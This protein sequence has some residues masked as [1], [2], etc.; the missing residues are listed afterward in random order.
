MN[1][2]PAYKTEMINTDLR[3]IQYLFESQGEK[4]IIK[5]IEYSLFRKISGRDVYN[6]GFGDYDEDNGTLIDDVNSNNGDMRKVFSTVLNSVPKF[7]STNKDSV[8]WVQGSDSTEE[9]KKNCKIDCKKNCDEICKKFNR[10]IKTYRYYVDKNFVEL[11]KEYIF[12][13]FTDI[14][15]PDFVQYIPENEYLGILVFK[16]K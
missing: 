1:N 6:L 16:K 15:N 7:F 11:S 2:I 13:G 14:E 9:F 5:A 8:I 10:R 12:F 4:S 3:K